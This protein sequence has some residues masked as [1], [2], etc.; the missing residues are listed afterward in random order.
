VIIFFNSFESEMHVEK[1]DV[2]GKKS[3]SIV[4]CMVKRQMC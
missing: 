4:K 2:L 1:T 3:H